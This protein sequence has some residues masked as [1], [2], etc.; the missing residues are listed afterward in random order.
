[1][2]EESVATTQPE[3]IG[4]VLRKARESRGLSIEQVSSATKIHIKIIQDL[5]MD[6]YDDL[7]AE[8]F[9]RGFIY[10]YSRF[11]GLS[12]KSLMEEHKVFLEEKWKKHS[13]KSRSVTGYAFERP[14]GEQSRKMLWAV[15][16]G[17][18]VLGILVIAIF[19]PSLK[20]K[21]HGHVEELKVAATPS[22]SPSVLP[23]NN[24]IVSLTSLSQS[25]SPASGVP[26]VSPSPDSTL[27][28]GIII[29]ATTPSPSPSVS[30]VVTPSPSPLPVVSNT[31]LPSPSP[32]V[33]IVAMP[34]TGKLDKLQNGSD[35]L[36]TEVKHKL[37]FKALADVIVQ[38]RCDEKTLMKFTLRKDRILVL[39]A[40]EEIRFQVS[41]PRSIG[42]SKGSSGYVA[43]SETKKTFEYKG[44]T[45]LVL[46]ADLK[47]KMS[48]KWE[49]ATSLPETPDPAPEAASEEK[50]EEAAV[51]SPSLSPTP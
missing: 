46:P 19:K 14:E 18:F 22:P 45:T 35:L 5:E 31:P 12:S 8:P 42:L 32:T 15:M 50:K 10:N 9:T 43:L 40:K 24:T 37:I 11:L 13:E 26:V 49:G 7:P 30:V 48:E 1:M 17:M 2:S 47:A 39:K 38:Y 16:G 4:L 33:S 25:G 27:S 29:P 34:A 6:R 20:H 3:T 44:A 28:A 51:P 36:N 41:N 23:T 21:K